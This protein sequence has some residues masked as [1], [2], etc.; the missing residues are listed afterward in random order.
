MC[1]HRAWDFFGKIDLKA[2]NSV[3]LTVVQFSFARS[4]GRNIVQS[5]ISL[6]LSESE[7]LAENFR[8]S[9]LDPSQL[10]EMQE[11]RNVRGGKSEW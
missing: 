1:V 5:I 10:K 9:L 3:N 7:K 4:D 11:I 2:V 6:S 8:I